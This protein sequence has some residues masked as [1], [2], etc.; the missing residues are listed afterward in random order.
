M[1]VTDIASEGKIVFIGDCPH[2]NYITSYTIQEYI[3]TTE[4]LTIDYPFIVSVYLRVRW[5]LFYFLLSKS[6]FLAIIIR[7]FFY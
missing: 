7:L 3:Y 2:S 5:V 4:L 6:N 1:V